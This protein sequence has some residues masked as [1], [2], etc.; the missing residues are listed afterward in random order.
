MVVILGAGLAGLAAA[1]AL[2]SRDVLLLER[3]EEPGGLCRSSREAGFTFDRTGHLLHLRDPEIRR[4]VLEL[5]PGGWAELHRSAWIASHGTL[6]PYPFQVNTSSLPLDVRLE[7]LRGFVEALR[8]E[9]RAPAPPPPAPRPLAPDLPWLTVAPPAAPDEPSFQ[10]WALR[11]FGAGFARHFFTPYNEK[12]WRRPLSQVTADWTSWSIPRP[13]LA[14]VLRGALA[15]SDK[16]FGYNPQFLYPREGGIDHLPRA[17]AARLPK[18]VL[19]VNA[20][21]ASLNAERRRVRLAVGETHE[22]EAVLVTL[23]LPT[24]ARL[25]EDLP[26]ELRAAAARLS[27]I[28]VRVVNL[29]VRGPAARP[30]AQWIYVPG[31]QAPYHRVGLPCTLTPAMAPAG[32]HSLVAEIAFTPGEAPTP[33]ESAAQTR[34]A[35]IAAG[36]LA[37]ERDVVLEQVLDIPEAYV[38]FDRARREALPALL[39]WYVERGVLPL[40]RYGAW[41]YL[42]MEDCLRHGRQAAAWVSAR[43]AGRAAAETRRR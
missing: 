29:G 9:Q 11:T 15:G 26:A 22:A 2:D 7:C 17:L 38:V 19:R 21:V 27:H 18:G 32:H 14:D 16:A 30:G 3:D 37:S 35:L 1:H 34:R 6:V 31:Q 25:T 28:S 42:S 8:H 43:R 24:L 12:L 5:L 13:E 40:G 41:D 4:L 36:L 33:A 39:R 23:P 20:A 10:D